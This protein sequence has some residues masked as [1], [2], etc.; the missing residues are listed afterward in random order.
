MRQL[1]G[2]F[3]VAVLVAVSAGAGSYSSAHFA[4]MKDRKSSGQSD[5]FPTGLAGSVNLS[6]LGENPPLWRP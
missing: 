2:A 6:S 5:G 1:G 3:G 4:G